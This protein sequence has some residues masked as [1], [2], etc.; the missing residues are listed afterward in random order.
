MEGLGKGMIYVPSRMEDSV[1]YPTTDSV[2]FDFLFI[3]FRWR[4]AVTETS[5][6]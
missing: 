6:K 3:V 5:E 4:M 2:Q 1:G